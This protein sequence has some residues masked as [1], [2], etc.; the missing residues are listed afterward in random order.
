MPAAGDVLSAG[1]CGEPDSAEGA[2][3]DS[4]AA[5]W[6]DVSVVTGAARWQAVANSNGASRTAENRNRDRIIVL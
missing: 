4:A 2:D 1:A 5:V 3:T 6:G